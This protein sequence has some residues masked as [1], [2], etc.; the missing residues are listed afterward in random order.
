MNIIFLGAP[1]AG[2]GTQAEIVSKTYEIPTL[3]TGVILREAIKNETEMGLAAKAYVEA[4]KLVTD[5]IVIGIIKDRLAQDD[6]KNGFILDGFPRTVP[7]AEALDAMGVK[8]DAVISID[9]PD[10][11][12]VKRMSGRRACPS[13]GS[14]YHIEFNPSKDGKN[15][16]NCGSELT[17]RRDDQPEVVLDRLKT[18][19]SQTAP[20]IDYY[21]GT[22]KLKT[23]IGQEE[24]KDTTRL[25]LEALES[26]LHCG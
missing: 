11:K 6:C 1:G 13:C 3:S 4:G 18:Y 2:K 12:I 16:D 5:E 17:T 20:L 22:G 19:H 25:T 15:C 8:I 24:V 21:G 10:E 26:V 9:V 14:T 7:Q 23:I